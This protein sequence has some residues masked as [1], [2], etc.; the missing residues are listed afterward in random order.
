VA[1]NFLLSR[2]GFGQALPSRDREE[3]VLT[4]WLRQATLVIGC[5]GSGIVIA[6]RGSLLK[7][8]ITESGMVSFRWSFFGSPTACS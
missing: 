7:V 2:L 6:S 5:R 8:R 1:L 4:F 3:A